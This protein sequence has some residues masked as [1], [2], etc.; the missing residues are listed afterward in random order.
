MNDKC[1][2]TDL[3]PGLPCGCTNVVNAIVM[4]GHG[5]S[6]LR[7]DTLLHDVI[8][9]TEYIHYCRSLGIDRIRQVASTRTYSYHKPGAE[10]L[11]SSSTAYLIATRTG[12]CQQYSS[13]LVLSS[14]EY[15]ILHFGTWHFLWYNTYKY[16][17]SSK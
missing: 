6:R 16:R 14:S 15:L 13:T 3:H 5:V 17:S 7:T 9:C 2:G 8:L 1:Q 4:Q 11:T 10:P 12:T